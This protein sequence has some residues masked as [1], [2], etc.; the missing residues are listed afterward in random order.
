VVRR[1]GPALAVRDVRLHAQ[2]LTLDLELVLW[3]TRVAL[4]A[5]V[6]EIDTTDPS[7]TVCRWHWAEGERAHRWPGRLLAHLPRERLDRWAA[8]RLGEGIRLEGERLVVDHRALAAR[9]LRR[10]G[11]PPADP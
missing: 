4:G 5:L 6:L 8:E 11:R 2:G 1:G 10:C 7:R 3:G 9:L